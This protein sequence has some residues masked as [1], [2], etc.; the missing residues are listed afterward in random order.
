MLVL[1]RE[2]NEVIQIGE[3]IRVVVVEIRG[4]KVRLGIE[5]P[6]DVQ[7]VRPDARNKTPKWRP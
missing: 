3:T 4:S 5:A 1:T 2:K 6:R 7:I